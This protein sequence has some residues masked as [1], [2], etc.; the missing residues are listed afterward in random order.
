MSYCPSC[1]SYPLECSVDPSEWDLPCKHF[2]SK[3]AV[4]RQEDT[5]DGG[6]KD[7]G[8]LEYSEDYDWGKQHDF[9]SDPDWR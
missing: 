5:V 3:E 8:P 7:E 1:I 6:D 9:D 4:F 2:Q